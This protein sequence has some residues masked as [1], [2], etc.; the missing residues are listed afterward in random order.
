M[1][2][3]AFLFIIVHSIISNDVEA[4]YVLKE[5]P[6]HLVKK[7]GIVDPKQVKF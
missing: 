4:N 2:I 7:F 6:A 5:I 1:K 3:T